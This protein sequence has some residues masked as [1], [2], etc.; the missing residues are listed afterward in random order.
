ML[1]SLKYS[2]LYWQKRGLANDN[3]SFI[4]CPTNYGKT[5]S[6]Y[7]YDIWHEKENHRI[8][9][10]PPIQRQS[11]IEKHYLK[12]KRNEQHKIRDENTT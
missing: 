6:N 11:H 10:Y 2:S 4:N 1:Y 5:Q 7:L 12:I 3:C 8:K 9:S